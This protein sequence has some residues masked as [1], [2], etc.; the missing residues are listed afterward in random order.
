MDIAMVVAA[1]IIATAI[2]VLLRQ[3][4]PEY[5]LMV[6]LAAGIVILI[7]L[8]RNILP[9]LDTINSLLS[10][11]GMQKQYIAILIKALGI[12]YLT[13]LACDTCKDAG[14]SAIGAK[15]EL[16]GRVAVLIVS[17]PLFES[18]LSLASG[19]FSL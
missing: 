10:Q 14:E 1:G 4:K 18:I 16:A 8:T 12:C 13:Q 15:I 6:S 17:L 2:A 9:V 7:A 19:L 3:Y 5:A 11:S